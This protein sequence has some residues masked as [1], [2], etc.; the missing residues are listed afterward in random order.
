MISESPA[1]P[2]ESLFGEVGGNLG[3][4]LGASLL[5]VTELLDIAIV[6]SLGCFIC[7]KKKTNVTNPLP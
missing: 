5:T 3:L 2:V 1:Y 6:S 7:R 4:F